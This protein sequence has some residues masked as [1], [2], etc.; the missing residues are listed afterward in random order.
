[1]ILAVDTLSA[2]V[3]GSAKAASTNSKADSQSCCANRASASRINALLLCLKFISSEESLGVVLHEMV[4]GEGPF[5]QAKSVSSRVA[6]IGTPATPL[7]KLRSE[8][9]R[10]DL[11]IKASAR[12]LPIGV[13]PEGSGA[14]TI[15]DNLR[16]DVEGR[17][18]K[19]GVT[20]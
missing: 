10:D 17:L 1:M 13:M 9:P 14:L 19:G 8:V 11:F 5:H 18:R 6:G 2:A 3:K 15:F 16:V 7:R 4:A 20:R 12:G